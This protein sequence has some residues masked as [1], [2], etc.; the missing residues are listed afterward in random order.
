LDHFKDI[1]KNIE[2]SYIERFY[3]LKNPPVHYIQIED[4]GFF[5]MGNDILNFGVP[6][7]NGK[8]YL[9]ARVKTR[10]SSKNRWGFLVA[11]KMPYIQ[12]SAYDIEEI[13]SKRFPIPEGDHIEGTM[14][15][16]L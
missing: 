9:R 10:S 5:Y 14:D 7:L 3:N 11:I 2:V 4:R 8:P 1:K 12:E 13:D 6:R 15:D 16:Y